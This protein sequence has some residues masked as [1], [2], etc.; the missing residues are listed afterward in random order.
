LWTVI[1]V[2]QI[3]SLQLP[4]T[5][6]LICKND[7][8]S[9]LPKK[10]PSGRYFA[11]PNDFSKGYSLRGFITFQSLFWDS[12]TDNTINHFTCSIMEDGD[13]VHFDDLL[14]IKPGGYQGVLL[15]KGDNRIS[16]LHSEVPIFVL[17]KE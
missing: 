3:G 7:D 16:K 17:R 13:V 14:H 5:Q 6:F 11:L 2:N 9:A 4:N 12:K 15:S 8:Y 1:D 10:F